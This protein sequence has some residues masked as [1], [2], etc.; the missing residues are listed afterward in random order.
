[1]S[2]AALDADQT[3]LLEMQQLL[4]SSIETLWRCSSAV[5]APSAERQIALPTDMQSFMLQLRALNELSQHFSAD[6]LIPV[7][8]FGYVDVCSRLFLAHCIRNT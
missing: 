5:D 4:S 7:E 1:M 3:R 8:V 6:F 2:N